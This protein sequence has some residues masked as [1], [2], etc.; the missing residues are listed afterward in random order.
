M[1]P[2]L[3]NEFY[4]CGSDTPHG[5]MRE[6]FSKIPWD[7][8]KQHRVIAVDWSL[9]DLCKWQL[10][11]IC[12]CWFLKQSLIKQFSI[13]WTVKSF[14]IAA[15]THIQKEAFNFI[16]TILA[17]NNVVTMHS[18]NLSQLGIQYSCCWFEYYLLLTQHLAGTL[19][20]Y[21]WIDLVGKWKKSIGVYQY[22]VHLWLWFYWSMIL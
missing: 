5:M 18:R 3:K 10:L 21:M 14:L 15:S 17:I 7:D 22:Q 12:E 6:Y 19:R 16:R 20:C 9:I 4:L 8:C 1:L 11:M 2:H 13:F